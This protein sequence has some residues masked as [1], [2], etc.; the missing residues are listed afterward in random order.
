MSGACMNFPSCDHYAPNQSGCCCYGPRYYEEEYSFSDFFEKVL[1]CL[2][3]GDL[4]LAS[5]PLGTYAGT[6]MSRFM[7]H[8]RSSHVGF[9]YRPSDC[10]EVLTSRDLVYGN[11]VNSTRPLFAQFLAGGEQGNRVKKEGGLD[12]VDAETFMKDYMDKF[13]HTPLS[14]ASDPTTINTQSMSVRFL[15]SVK[16]DRAFYEA[17]QRCIVQN[18]NIPFD[19]SPSQ[20]TFFDTLENLPCCCCEIVK[21]SVKDGYICSE[22][23]AQ[24]YESIGL[25]S[26]KN[27]STAEYEPTA[28]DTTRKLLLLG[29]AELSC[30]Y[31]VLG[32]S[33]RAQRASFGYP[34]MANPNDRQ[35]VS[36]KAGGFWGVDISKAMADQHAPPAPPTTHVE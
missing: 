28:F 15:H 34:D 31:R 25:V 14:I 36:T 27:K 8:S 3:T 17:V 18:L 24:M 7:G 5:W 9:V 2:H 29:G 22:F 32:A 12:I 35:D 20:K 13:A 16:R 21:S 4:I 10:L 23:V 11:L 1:P 6:N 19:N 26:S 30:E 33:T